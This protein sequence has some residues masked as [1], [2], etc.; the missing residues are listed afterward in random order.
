MHHPL[1]TKTQWLTC[2]TWLSK[3]K[4]KVTWSID[5]LYNFFFKMW[6]QILFLL[7]EEYLCI[8]F[9]YFF[10]ATKK[11]KCCIWTIRWRGGLKRGG[12]KRGWGIKRITL[13]F[14]LLKEKN[15]FPVLLLVWWYHQNS[16]KSCHQISSSKTFPQPHKN[17]KPHIWPSLTFSS[18]IN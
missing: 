2:H 18:N 7:N 8:Y 15:I 5:M 11:S 3:G 4:N 10:L 1:K 9:I 17:L 16:S 13:I 6:F 14:H 12:L